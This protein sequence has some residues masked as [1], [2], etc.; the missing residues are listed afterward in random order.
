MHARNL[1]VSQPWGDPPCFA[2]AQVLVVDGVEVVVLHMPCKGGKEH[3]DVQH[4]RRDARDL[5]LQQPKR[6]IV[7]PRQHL[8]RQPGMI[9]PFPFDTKCH[10]SQRHPGNFT[11]GRPLTS[12]PGALQGQKQTAVA[13]ADMHCCCDVPGSSTWKF[14]SVSLKGSPS[15]CELKAVP[16]TSLPYST[17]C[18]AELLRCLQY[19]A[20]N[21]HIFLTAWHKTAP[22]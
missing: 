14:Q 19:S 6:R 7:Q 13:W 1:K 9:A 3:A 18:S 16:S 21:I 20:C 11:L 8:P 12:M 17:T 5:T 22:H 10:C 4:G 15:L 2:G